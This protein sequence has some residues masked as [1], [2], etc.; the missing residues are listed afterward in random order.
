MKSRLIAAFGLGTLVAT[1]AIGAVQFVSAA[2]DATITACASKTT[3]V[4][5]Y[6]TKGSCKKTETAL[7]WNQQGPQGLQGPQGVAG[8]KG[9]AGLQG[10]KGEPGTAPNL[11]S[12][13]KK[14]DVVAKAM[15]TQ[16]ISSI[17]PA[18]GSTNLVPGSVSAITSA[19]DLLGMSARSYTRRYEIPANWTGRIE[20]RCPDD[21]PVPLTHGVFA[22]DATGTKFGDDGWPPY[23]W[24]AMAQRAS[25][26]FPP[27]ST[28]PAFTL[29]VT[30]VCG[31][32]TLTVP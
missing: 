18:L 12:F 8:E 29:Y 13:A 31:P 5:R 26:D 23:G 21:A 10:A 15:T 16:S 27:G 22:L 14:E 7:S 1:I 25:I 4:M 19:S 11:E 9:A 3:G 17:S 2:S 32:I 24:Y 20:G 6:I 30:Q 28:W